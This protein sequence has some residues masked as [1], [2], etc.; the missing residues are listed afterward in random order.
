MLLL[1][2]ITFCSKAIFCLF[3]C[4]ALSARAELNDQLVQRISQSKS[5]LETIEKKNSQESRAYAQKLAQKE[6]EVKNLRTQLASQQRLVDEQL[7]G[8]DKIKERVDQWSAQSKY[9]KQL[10]IHYS[11]TA[12]LPITLKK[13]EELVVL[14][15]AAKQLEQALAPSWKDA[16]V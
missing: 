6:Q 12:K 2:V 5:E 1:R 15:A 9:Q 13:D 16:K 8:I 7:L 11:D 3:V 4:S 10:L 14:D